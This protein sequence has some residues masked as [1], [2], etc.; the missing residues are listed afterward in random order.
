MGHNPLLLLDRSPQ[1]VGGGEDGSEI[2]A[3]VPFVD[4]IA[5]DRARLRTS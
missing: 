2:V 3:H 5:V 4:Y 1:A